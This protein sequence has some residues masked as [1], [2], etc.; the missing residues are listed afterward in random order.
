[1]PTEKRL[2]KVFICHASQDEPIVREHYL[3]LNSEGWIDPWL[4][5]ERSSDNLR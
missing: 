2:L 4:D 1:M 5:E 3:R